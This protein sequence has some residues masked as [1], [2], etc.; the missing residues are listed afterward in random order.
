MAYHA[1]PFPTPHLFMSVSSISWFKYLSVNLLDPIVFKTEVDSPF[2]PNSYLYPLSKVEFSVLYISS[3]IEISNVC[4]HWL[5]PWG[6][7]DIDLYPLPPPPTPAPTQSPP[8][9]V[10]TK[11]V[12]V[13][14]VSMV[15]PILL[16]CIHIHHHIRFS[17][18]S[19]RVEGENKYLSFMYEKTEDPRGWKT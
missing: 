18:K 10:L 17:K 1:I 12:F 9:S 2:P 6:Q 15:F 11:A 5:A 4:R 14:Y 13:H 8:W 16:R 3:S 19:G 7:D